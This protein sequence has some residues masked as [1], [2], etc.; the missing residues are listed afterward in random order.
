MQLEYDIIQCLSFPTACFLY[1]IPGCEFRTG[2]GAMARQILV[3]PIHFW[4]L[5]HVSRVNCHTAQKNCPPNSQPGIPYTIK[6]KDVPQ[7]LPV[8]RVSDLILNLFVSFIQRKEF[9]K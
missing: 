6:F 7:S 4:V 3:G 1:S 5:L 2:P 9:L 8:E